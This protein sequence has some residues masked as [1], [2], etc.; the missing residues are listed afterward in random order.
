MG[1]DGAG[2]LRPVIDDLNGSALYKLGSAL[3]NP[4]FGGTYAADDTVWRQGPAGRLTPR[5]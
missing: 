5:G 3:A 1:V 2:F 4:E